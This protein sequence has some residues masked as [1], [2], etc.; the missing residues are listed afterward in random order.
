MRI[1]LQFSH[2]SRKVPYNYQYD[3]ARHLHKWL[4]VDNEWHSQRHNPLSFGCLSQLRGGQ[5]GLIIHGDTVEWWVGSWQAQVL[6]ALIRGVNQNPSGPSEFGFRVQSLQLI[7]EPEFGERTLFWA[8]SPIVLKLKRNP[9]PD[10]YV[11]FSDEEADELLR[12]NLLK[13]LKVHGVEVDPADV[14]VNF[15]R[16]YPKAK[17]RL[18]RLK[19]QGKD[20]SVR[21]SI[22]PVM[23][24]AP[25]VVHRFVWAAG[26]G[27]S[28]GVGFGAV[29]RGLI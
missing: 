27:S 10:R 23:L 7:P 8:E 4:G 26:L 24:E 25:P 22:C 21:G 29:R 19:R 15:H 14:K 5:G 9:L 13:K 3:L 18:I 1:K 11:I 16:H 12:E 28:T 2:Q 17:T 6:K 20:V